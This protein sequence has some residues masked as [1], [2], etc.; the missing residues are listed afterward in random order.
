ML[1]NIALVAKI[2]TWV[3][4]F[5][6]SL[7]VGLLCACLSLKMSGFTMGNIHGL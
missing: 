2:S 3:G 5:Q 4:L 6:L 7:V 1:P